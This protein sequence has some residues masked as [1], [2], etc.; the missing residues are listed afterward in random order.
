[1]TTATAEKTEQANT[2]EHSE[3]DTEKVITFVANDLLKNATVV[4]LLSGVPVNTLIQLLQSQS[5]NR[6]KQAVDGLSD[7]EFKNL[8]ESANNSPEVTSGTSGAE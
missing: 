8:L 4:D 1:M 2:N 7:E 6:A 3:Q 5:I